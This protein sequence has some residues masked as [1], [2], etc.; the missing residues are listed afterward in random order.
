[1]LRNDSCY[2]QYMRSYRSTLRAEQARRTRGIVIDAAEVCF[3][4]HGYAATT[5]KEIAAEAGVSLQ[6]VFAQGSKA[7]LLLAVVDRGVAG[8]DA[9]EAILQREPIR[10]FMEARDKAEL[11]AALR[12]LVLR[13]LPPSEAPLRVFKDA[14]GG[15]PELAAAWAEYERR[16]YTDALAMIGSMAHL[17]RD[18]LTVEQ[19]TDIYWA[20]LTVETARNFRAVRGWSIDRYADWLVDAVD[21]LLLA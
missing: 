16:R 14:A 7:A 15:D 9:D 19:A 21:R 3:L 11:L 18:D 8:D 17:L 6:T 5:M 13:F 2:G 4:A 12:V 20:T 1:M 10:A